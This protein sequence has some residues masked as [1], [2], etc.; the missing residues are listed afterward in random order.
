M[1]FILRTVIQS[2]TFTKNSLIYEFIQKNNR[3]ITNDVL[4]FMLL[5]RKNNIIFIINK[6]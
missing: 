1:L 5:D 4:N 2:I 3:I 6:I